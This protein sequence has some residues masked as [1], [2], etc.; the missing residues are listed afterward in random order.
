MLL[1]ARLTDFE[2]NMR[3]A[4][5]VSATNFGAVRRNSR[6]A[7]M[8]I[9]ADMNRASARINQAVATTS[10]RI[11]TVAKAMA[12][13]AAG[14]ITIDKIAR[15]AAAYQGMAN[16]LRIAGLE[17]EQLN[18]T[19]GQLF[20]IAQ[21][22]GSALEPL[23]SLFARLSQSQTELHASSADLTRFTEGVSLALKVAGT[24]AT[25]ASGALTQLA[26][27]LGGGTVR[28]EEFNSVNEGA[29][30]ILDAVAAGLKEAGGSVATLRQLVNDG[31]VSS[32]AFFRAF[33]AGAGSLQEKADKAL[34]SVEQGMTRV[35]NA[36]TVAVGEF[37][38]VTGAST[39]VSSGLERIAAGIGSV[40][41]RAEAVYQKIKPLVDALNLIGKYSPT[42]LL[43]QYATDTGVFAPT[44]SGGV[45]RTTTTSAVNGT[46]AGAAPVLGTGFSGGKSQV[47]LAQY[48][49]AGKEKSSSSKARASE[50]EQ[51]IAS[52]QRHTQALQ[53]QAGQFGMTEAEA[54]RYEATQQLLNAATADGKTITDDQ[55]AA[56][57]RAADAYAQAADAAH[58]MTEKT[59]RA[60]EFQREFESA[61]TELFSSLIKGGDS[62]N[63]T[64]SRLAER[65]ADLALQAA[66]FGSGPFGS[67]SG[68]LSGVGKAIGGLF[69]GGSDFSGYNVT[70]LPGHATGGYI[71]GPGTGTSD[72]I[73]ARLS[74]GEYVFSARAV[75][76]IGAGNLDAMHRT[77]KGFAAGGYVGPAPVASGQAASAAPVIT[78]APTINFQSQIPSSQADQASMAKQV[79]RSVE[80]AVNQALAKQMRPGGILTR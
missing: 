52:L 69:G 8:Q 6:S 79:Q 65:F 21:R 74:N 22:N 60:A 38:K 4:S 58:Q 33:L 5:A 70:G 73:P 32:E 39:S 30:P 12:A 2:R 75:S 80:T 78:V 68:L 19:F 48:P 10:D 45:T 28:A 59:Q 71:R 67:G 27:A 18:G 26:Q 14:A 76:A 17:G 23:V 15:A 31:K 53:I 51:E 29:R 46:I 36:F 54:A 56:I 25:A 20:A 16:A 62:L 63:D 43:T 57:A 13:A 55:R 47:S 66:L 35:A 11:G 42:G 37:D 24:D 34:P 9:E 50:L 1:E 41:D 7:T 44:P 3:K 61:T 40:G 49:A 77:A 64:L 72:S